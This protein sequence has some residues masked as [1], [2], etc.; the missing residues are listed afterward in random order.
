[1]TFTL[2]V[3]YQ[4]GH[5][6]SPMYICYRPQKRCHFSFCKS[7]PTLIIISQLHLMMI[8]RKLITSSC[9]CCYTA[10]GISKCSTIPICSIYSTQKWLIKIVCL[11]KISIKDVKFTFPCCVCRLIHNM[12][13]KS[14]PSAHTH[15]AGCELMR[16]L[17]PLL[18]FQPPTPVRFTS[19]APR[20]SIK[21]PRSQSI[22]R[23][24]FTLRTILPNFTLIDPI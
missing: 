20:G 17:N 8:C 19:S 2:T 23:C 3:D 4:N 16:G 15:R 6:S 12:C 10:L 7:E 14:R 24:V 22:N 1:M 11:Q 18:H 13:S 21:S 9:K 5:V